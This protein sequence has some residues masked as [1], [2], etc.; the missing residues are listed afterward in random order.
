MRQNAQICAKALKMSQIC[1]K[2]TKFV[3]NTISSWTMHQICAKC[4][5]NAPN[6]CKTYQISDKAHQICAESTKVA[7]MYQ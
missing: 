4:I 1:A 6:L 3:L 5:Q 2:W 7:K